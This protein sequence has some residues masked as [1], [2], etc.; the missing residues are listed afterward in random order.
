LNFVNSAI[1]SGELR[2]HKGASEQVVIKYAVK[3]EW[4]DADFE[5]KVLRPLALHGNIIHCL[6]YIGTPEKGQSLLE[7]CELGT[8]H[9]VKEPFNYRKAKIRLW[10][11]GLYSHCQ[12]LG[13]ELFPDK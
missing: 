4:F 2:I 13:L 11:E 7:Y 10:L 12:S 1:S 5:V 9:N 8:P 6:E 3:G